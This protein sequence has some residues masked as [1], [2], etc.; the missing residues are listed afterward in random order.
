MDVPLLVRTIATCDSTACLAA[1]PEIVL[2]IKNGSPECLLTRAQS[3]LPR[4]QVVLLICLLLFSLTNTVDSFLS[5]LSLFLPPHPSSFQVTI[6]P[7]NCR[8]AS[9]PH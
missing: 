6:V 3:M 9:L 2:E 5:A 8:L 4:F 1:P 7:C